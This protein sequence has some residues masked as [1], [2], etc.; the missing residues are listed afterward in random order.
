MPHPER[1]HA[2]WRDRAHLREGQG[3]HPAASSL[4]IDR[5]TANKWRRRSTRDRICGLYDELRPGRPRTVDDERVAELIH[6][7]LHAKPAGDSTP[8]STRGLAAEIG[9]GKTTVARHLKALRL[10]PPRVDQSVGETID[11]TTGAR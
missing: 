3:Q 1:T 8:W 7:T 2:R 4:G 9:I 10:K 6:K 5:G 11:W